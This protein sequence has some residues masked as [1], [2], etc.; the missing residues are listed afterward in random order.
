MPEMPAEHPNKAAFLARVREALGRTEPI[1]HT[2][3]HAPLKSNQT[4]QEEKVRTVLARVAARRSVLCERLADVAAR[5]SWNVHR[6]ATPDR[7]AEVLADIADGLKARH[8]VRTAEDVFTRVDVDG[9][10][11]R[12]GI[13]PAILAAGR[14]RRRS[15][16][17]PMAF[18]AD[19]GIVGVAY[20]IA[21]TAS[22]AV[23]Q[24]KGVARLASLAPPVLAVVVEAE[25]VLESLDD[26][27]AVMRLEYQKGRSHWA[28]YF[29][30][31]SGPSRTADIEQTLTIGVH[32][33]GQVHLVLVG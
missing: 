12:E 6:A 30:F 11:R 10:L 27:F 7:A 20:A 23:I 25:Q 2:P 8:V 3:D 22:C 33:P 28:P 5:A 29:N 21:E 17:K 18:R 32:G 1:L 26:F 4:R 15:E 9:A 31:I 14:A 16:L 19:L 24:R 13:S